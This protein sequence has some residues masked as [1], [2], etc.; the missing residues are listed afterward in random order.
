MTDEIVFTETL[1]QWWSRCN[2]IWKTDT[3]TRRD[4]PIVSW[5]VKWTARQQDSN[6]AQPIRQTP[7]RSVVKRPWPPVWTWFALSHGKLAE[8]SAMWAE[9]QRPAIDRAAALSTD[10]RRLSRLIERSTNVALQQSNFDRTRATT[11]VWQTLELIMG[12]CT[13]DARRQRTS[14]GLLYVRPRHQCR[15]LAIQPLHHNLYRTSTQC[16]WEWD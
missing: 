16:K 15:F 2:A 4:G 6:A 1:K 8:V 9:R 5:R 3:V 10:C 11:R 7:R 12:Y 14:D 13:V